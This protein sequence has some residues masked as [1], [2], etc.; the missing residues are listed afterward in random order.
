MWRTANIDLRRWK[1]APTLRF[2]LESDLG[3]GAR[4]N[5]RGWTPNTGLRRVR[6]GTRSAPAPEFPRPAPEFP[7]PAP[8][9]LRPAPEFLRPAPEFP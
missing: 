8:E 3:G 7:R 4:R 1:A 2:Q 6:V 9:F 5:C